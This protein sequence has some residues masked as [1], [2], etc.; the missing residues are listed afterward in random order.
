VAK[1]R[2]SAGGVQAWG[3][4]LA[5]LGAQLRVLLLM[6][7]VISATIVVSNLVPRAPTWEKGFTRGVHQCVDLLGPW[8]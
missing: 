4:A 5:Y 6:A 3:E 8:K 7:G 1:R 2:V